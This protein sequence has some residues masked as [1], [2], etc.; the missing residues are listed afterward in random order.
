MRLPGLKRASG[1]VNH[2]AVG[3]TIAIDYGSTTLKVLQLSS[4]STPTLLAAGC[5]ETPEDL[6]GNIKQRLEFQFEALPKL[7]SSLKL[8]GRRAACVIPSPLTFCKHV[9]F[10]KQDGMPPEVL[11]DTMLTEQLDRDASTL[12]RRLI[13]VPGTDRASSSGKNEYICLATGR[14]IIDKLMKAIRSAKLEPVGMHSE[15]EATLHAFHYLN[16]RDSDIDRATLYLDMG[17]G[18]TQVVIGH[19]KKLVFARTIGIG[20]LSLDECL[21][22]ALACSI[23][24]ARK[25]RLAMGD[26]VPRAAP[27]RSAVPALAMHT[28]EGGVMLADDRRDRASPP[29]LSPEVAETAPAPTAP[30]GASLLEPL[31]ILADE[32]GMCVRYHDTMFPSARVSNV[33]LVGGEARHRGLCQHIAQSLR[34]PARVADPL[35]LITKTGQEHVIGLD[36]NSP[37]PGW[38]VPIG[39]CQC[40]TDL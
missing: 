27:A 1:T 23:V 39:L 6:R 26:L 37:L 34:L 3:A 11:A 17:G 19:G 33:I 10:P 9:Q 31:E 20:G 22:Q 8:K 25:A 18:Q 14:E 29:G 13:P 28:D 5:V 21:A 12:V 4:E 36:L 32:A 2:R 15:F 38:V 24:Q 40:P 35:S 16:R 7:V 30:S